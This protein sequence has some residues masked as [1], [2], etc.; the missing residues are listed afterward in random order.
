[1]VEPIAED[2]DEE[3]PDSDAEG[4]IPISEEASEKTKSL[5]VSQT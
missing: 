3:A 4:R 2:L 5:S 1:L